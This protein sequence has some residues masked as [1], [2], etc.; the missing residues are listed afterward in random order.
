MPQLRIYFFLGLLFHFA[1]HCWNHLIPLKKFQLPWRRQVEA[2]LRKH[3]LDKHMEKCATTWQRQKRGQIALGSRV[4]SSRTRRKSCK[5]PGWLREV[6]LMKILGP[7][8]K[9]W[10]CDRGQGTI[11]LGLSFNL[12]NK[13]GIHFGV[14]VWDNVHSYIPWTFIWKPLC[15]KHCFNNQSYNC[16]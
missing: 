15:S 16:E 2:G 6:L 9:Y 4:V 13:H 12:L 7:N 10:L 1:A 3:F 5:S 11:A 14:F 8:P